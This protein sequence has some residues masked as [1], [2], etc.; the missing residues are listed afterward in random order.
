MNNNWMQNEPETVQENVIAGAVGA[1]LFAL[2]GGVRWFVIYLLG[3]LAS[4]SGLVGVI[5]AIKG[6]SVFAKKESKKG[7]VIAVILA[8]LVLVLAWYLCIAYD[9]YQA[10]QGWFEQGEVDFTLN[11]FES[12]R[13]V[14]YFLS[15]PEIASAY[16]RDLAIGLIFAVIGAGSHVFNRIKNKKQA[17]VEL[18][19]TDEA[20]P[21][22]PNL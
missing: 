11:F 14:P 15:E 13:A 9:I 20:D 12:A 19:K 17:P 3:Y 16:V 5:C 4:I 21:S 18:P 6:Y 8:L 10:Y 2:V 22:D 7:I 1:F